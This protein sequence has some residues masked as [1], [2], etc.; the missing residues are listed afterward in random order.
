MPK[1]LKTID[2]LFED[3][4]FVSEIQK[5]LP[6]LF[7]IAEI[8]S[9]R[10]GKIGM[11]VGSTRENVLIALLIYVF[12]NNAVNPDFAI[13]ATEKDVEL[14]GKPISIKTITNNGYVKAIWTVDAESVSRWA[15]KY[16]PKMDMLLAQ[17]CWDTKDGG[18]FLI[19][20]IVQVDV[21][22]KLGR[23]KYLK[24]PKLGT[25]P[26][27]VEFS[28]EAISSMIDDKR[29]HKIE[30]NWVK[31][32]LPAKSVYQRWIDAWKEA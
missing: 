31:L 12:G 19:P 29:T 6:K 13:T 30:I 23:E 18:L 22:K 14:D 17:I 3:K 4:F 24:L 21:F 7:R 10:A 5:K 25:N 11:Q 2:D 26:R 20:A 1:Q 27:G 32:D 28:K 15:E 8:E 9:S 16:K